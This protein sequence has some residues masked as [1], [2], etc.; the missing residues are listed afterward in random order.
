M[1]NE[2]QHYYRLQ[3][4]KD[5]YWA[6][7]KAKDQDVQ[8]FALDGLADYYQQHDESLTAAE[9]KALRRIIDRTDNRDTAST[10][11]QVLINA[12]IMDELE[13][14]VVM[15]DWKDKHWGR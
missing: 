13:A 10:C 7:T 8:F 3:G 1:L 12:G 11:C 9:Q 5:I 15:D 6:N 4:H 2:L 14:V